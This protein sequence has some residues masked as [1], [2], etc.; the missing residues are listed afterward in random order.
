METIRQE[1]Q[2]G[3]GNVM[4]AEEYPLEIQPSWGMARAHKCGF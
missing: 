3:N 2:A 1:T 4:A